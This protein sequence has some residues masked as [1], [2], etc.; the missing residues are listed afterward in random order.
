MRAFGD[1]DI[2]SCTICAD[3]F[4]AIDEVVQHGTHGF[5]AMVLGNNSSFQRRRQRSMA[6]GDSADA[7]ISALRA[8]VTHLRRL[9]AERDATISFLNE[10]LLAERQRSIGR[11]VFTPPLA[12]T[13]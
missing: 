10:A 8:Q 11:V 2:F 7:E 9:V 1:G 3:T 13:Q 6:I 4:G 5:D 12:L